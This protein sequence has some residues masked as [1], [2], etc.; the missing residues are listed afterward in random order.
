MQIGYIDDAGELGAMPVTPRPNDQPVFA[1][2]ML[3]VEQVRLGAIVPEYLQLKRNYFPGLIP[4]GSEFLDAVKAEIKGADL[5]RDVANGARNKSRHARR[6]LG[7]V[8]SLCERAKLRLVCKVT[9]KAPGGAVNQQAVYTSSC[10]SLMQTFDHHLTISS[11]EGFVIADSRNHGLNVPVAHSIFTQ[12][13]SSKAAHYPRI[14]EL[15]TFGHSENHVGVQICDLLLSAIVV[16]VAAHT[17][18]TGVI[19]NVHVKPGYAGLKA[20]FATRLKEMQHRYQ[21]GEGKWRGGI[22]VNDGIGKRSSS[23]MFR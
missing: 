6:F 10:Q 1:L 5:R 19:S 12:M 3:I 22:T 16:P 15:P 7:E 13:F 8:F 17:Y 18:C 2:G 11:T 20:E 14:M 9:I 23:M 21:D 4:P